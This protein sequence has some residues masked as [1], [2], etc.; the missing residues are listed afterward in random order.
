MRLGF[1][2]GARLALA[3]GALGLLTGCGGLFTAQV[4]EGPPL[5]TPQVSLSTGVAGTVSSLTAALGAAGIGFFP[6]I[7]PYRPSEPESLVGA[8]RAVYQAG[9]GDPAQ[10]YVMVYQLTDASAAGIAA[11]ELATYLASGFGQ[12]N[13][14][15]DTQFHVATDGSTVIF[16]WWSREH[17]ADAE[18]AETA[19]DAIGTVGVPIRVVK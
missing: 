16:T 12:T 11:Q 9:I 4:D 5:P 19:F 6:P 17:A 13:Y 7:T 8:P 14:P 2:R 10:G 18:V 3:A 15:T 1:R